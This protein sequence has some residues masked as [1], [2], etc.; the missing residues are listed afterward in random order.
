MITSCA[1]WLR[2]QEGGKELHQLNEF[3]M[4]YR[5]VH[6]LRGSIIRFII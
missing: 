2:G 6:M 3:F 5:V 4:K 1:V